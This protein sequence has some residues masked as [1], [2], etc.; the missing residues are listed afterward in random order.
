[1]G[2]R[3]SKI[4]VNIQELVLHDVE[5]VDAA[6][7]SAVVRRELA[8]L[9]A[10]QGPLTAGTVRGAGSH[11]RASDA[12]SEGATEAVGVQVARVVFRRL[13]R[14]RQDST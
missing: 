6:G 4:D 14:C 3:P 8:R 10:K 1:M 11:R 13:T 7:I 9:T 2:D 12:G 5:A